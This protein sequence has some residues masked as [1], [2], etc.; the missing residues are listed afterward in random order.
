[1]TVARKKYEQGLVIYA[2]A[3]IRGQTTR[4]EAR[5]SNCKHR[6]P[7]DVRARKKMFSPPLIRFDGKYVKSYITF[8]RSKRTAGWRRLQLRARRSCHFRNQVSDICV[9]LG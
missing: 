3:E 1:M 6:S 8:A 7:T 4:I 2:N 9:F 5:Q